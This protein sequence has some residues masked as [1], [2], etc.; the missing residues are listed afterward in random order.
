[1][2]KGRPYPPDTERR[3]CIKTELALRNMS[4]ADL[5]RAMRIH[6]GHLGEIINGIRRSKKTEEKIA[7]FFGK[8]IKELFPPRTK[9]DLENM[10]KA[11]V[12]RGAA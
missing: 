4:I 12:K 8:E 11:A 9:R 6:Q 2:K 3:V 1:M 5:S 7:A 10:R